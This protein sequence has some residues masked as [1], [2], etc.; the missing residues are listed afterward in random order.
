MSNER[1]TAGKTASGRACARRDW[2][3]N[4]ITEERARVAADKLLTSAAARARSSV[5]PFS[6]QSRRAH[7]RP[8]AVFPAVVLS[9]LMAF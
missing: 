4:G 7:A 1:T 6:P 9:L 5:I 2:G 8:L 3:E